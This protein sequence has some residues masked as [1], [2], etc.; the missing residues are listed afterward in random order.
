M[1]SSEFDDFPKKFKF[2]CFGSP[3]MDLI[4]DVDD[5]FVRK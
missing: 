3:L 2:L 1:E 5:E 4:A